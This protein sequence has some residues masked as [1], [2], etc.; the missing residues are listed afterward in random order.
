MGILGELCV[1]VCGESCI[2]RNTNRA[3]SVR[4]SSKKHHI[5]YSKEVEREVR[6]FCCSEDSLAVPA[7]PSGEGMLAP[8]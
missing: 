5:Y 8:R 7:C 6:K 2:I 3:M 1:C 4:R